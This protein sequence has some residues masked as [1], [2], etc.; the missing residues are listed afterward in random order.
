MGKGQLVKYN[1]NTPD[2]AVISG[3]VA[4]INIL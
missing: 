2:G 3:T 4:C 1:I